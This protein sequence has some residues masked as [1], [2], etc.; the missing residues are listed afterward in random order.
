MDTWPW[1]LAGE[2]SGISGACVPSAC[3]RPKV[4]HSVLCPADLPGKWALQAGWGTHSGCS[5]GQRERF[6]KLSLDGF[7]RPQARSCIYSHK[8]R[9][10]QTSPPTDRVTLCD[11]AI[12]YEHYAVLERAYR[13]P[14][15][16]ACTAGL[17]PPATAAYWHLHRAR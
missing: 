6:S 2:N 4:V 9:P 13:S 1:R 10:P 16:S 14:N 8:Q 3:C 7:D 15:S 12:R 5:L 17:H 11:L